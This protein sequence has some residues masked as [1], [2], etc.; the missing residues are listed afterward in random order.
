MRRSLTQCETASA[1]TRR[2]RQQ[3][4]CSGGQ[5]ETIKYVRTHVA[6]TAPV[7][8]SSI[9]TYGLLKVHESYGTRGSHLPFSVY[10][11]KKRTELGALRQQDGSI[12]GSL[13]EQLLCAL[14]S[15]VLTERQR[16][17]SPESF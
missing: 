5:D 10:N 2:S 15:A 17:H 11:L 4:V 1:P 13:C 3:W 8:F 12:T 7:S 9:R 16:L 14:V 6:P